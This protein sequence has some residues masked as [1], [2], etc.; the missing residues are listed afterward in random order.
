VYVRTA[1]KH[2]ETDVYHI[3]ARGVGQQLIFETDADKRHYLGTLRDQL[4]KSSGK[5][6]AW[7]LMDNHVHLLV[8]Q[9]IDVLSKTMRSVNSGYALYFNLV[10]G[11]SGHLFQGRFRSEPVDDDAYLMTVVRYIH[12]NPMKAEMTRGCSYAWSSYDAYASG[13]VPEGGE[14]VLGAFG[15]REAFRKFHEED[16]SEAGCIDFEPRARRLDDEAAL[17]VGLELFG[18]SGLGEIKGL[19]RAER[20]A[21]LATLRKRGLTVRQ[22]QRLA[23]VSLG[24]ISK[25]GRGA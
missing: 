8:E 18:D 20:D 17:A 19:P 1:R 2:G 10:H 11:R 5:L 13:D 25:A 3:T 21:R 4:K 7:C 16:G 12:Q 24:V 14:L 6:L 22:V 15:S 23:G 9:P